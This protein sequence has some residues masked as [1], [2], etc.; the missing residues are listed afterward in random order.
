MNYDEV[1]PKIRTIDRLFDKGAMQVTSYVYYSNFRT[2]IY[3]IIGSII[4]AILCFSVEYV[5]GWIFGRIY[6]FLKIS[7]KN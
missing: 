3:C 4:T 5:S 7:S 2:W 1:T 6:I